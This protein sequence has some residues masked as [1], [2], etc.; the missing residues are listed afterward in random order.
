MGSDDSGLQ[1]QV[2]AAL[3]AGK[4][5]RCE[6]LGCLDFLLSRSMHLSG[7]ACVAYLR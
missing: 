1:G 3:A 5:R 2:M 4:P 6:W 7:D